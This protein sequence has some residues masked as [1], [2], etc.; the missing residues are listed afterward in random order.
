M[1]QTNGNCRIDTQ[2]CCPYSTESTT[3]NNNKM[4]FLSVVLLWCVT[5]A[6]AS[7]GINLTVNAKG[8][9]SLEKEELLKFSENGTPDPETLNQ[10]NLFRIHLL[11][12]LDSRIA[13]VF[14]LEPLLS[15]D[16]ITKPVQPDNGYLSNLFHYVFGSTTS[17]DNNDDNRLH[18][19]WVSVRLFSPGSSS[20]STSAPEYPADLVIPEGLPIIRATVECTTYL[21]LSRNDDVPGM[22]IHLHSSN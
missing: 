13:D 1:H 18:D 5:V 17:T 15:C 4:L 9:L 6:S 20:S 10:V 19:M 11:Q 22:P 12:T 21:P 7:E 16:S 2:W 3:H 14:N 8:F